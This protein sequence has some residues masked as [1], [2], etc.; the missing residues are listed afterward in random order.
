V[1]DGGDRH[2]LVPTVALS[3]NFLGNTRFGA[4][5]WRLAEMSVR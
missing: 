4:V 5:E 1:P 2:Q 3:Y